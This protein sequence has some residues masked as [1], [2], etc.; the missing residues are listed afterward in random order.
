MRVDLRKIQS[1]LGSRGLLE[2]VRGT[3]PHEANGISDDS[4][5]VERG[6]L[7]IAVR[8]WQ[9]DGHDFLDSAA[10]RGAACAIVEDG[11]E[12]PCRRWSCARGGSPPPSPR[13]L[14]TAIPRN[15][16]I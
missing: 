13:L 8:G 14:R 16:S 5:T 2:G 10:A 9:S 7:F 11:P 3:L 1:V 15:S 12:P 4:R 6:G